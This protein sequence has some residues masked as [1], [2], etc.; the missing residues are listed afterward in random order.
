M[1]LKRLAIH[2][3]GVTMFLAI[4]AQGAECAVISGIVK[5]MGAPISADITVVAYTGNPCESPQEAGRSTI[6]STG[7]YSMVVPPRSGDTSSYTYYLQAINGNASAFLDEWWT[8]TG[9]STECAGAE[10]V[11]VSSPTSAKTVDFQ[12]D[13][14]ATISGKVYQSDGTTSITSASNIVNIRIGAYSGLPC[15]TETRIR[16]ADIDIRN[17]TYSIKGLPAGP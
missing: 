16:Y 17:S 9:G 11:V 15:S 6:S 7:R 8:S 12:L 1:T 4:F 14:G 5:Y 3:V 13:K 10:G 2:F